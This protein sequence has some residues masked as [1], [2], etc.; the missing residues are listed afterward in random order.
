MSVV[1]WGQIHNPE[2][3][4]SPR[5]NVLKRGIPCRHRKFD[6]QIK[7]CSLIGLTPTMAVN[8][9]HIWAEDVKCRIRSFPVIRWYRWLWQ[10]IIVAYDLLF[11]LNINHSSTCLHWYW[12]LTRS[13]PF[14][15]LPVVIGPSS[16]GLSIGVYSNHVHKTQHGTDRQT[17]GWQ[18]NALTPLVEGA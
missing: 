13:K 5:T 12:G 9:W 14:R 17:N 16:M 10:V 6:Q 4:G 11:V 3:R 8:R 1:Y 18:L 2:F 7:C 15:P